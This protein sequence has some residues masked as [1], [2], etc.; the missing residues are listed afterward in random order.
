[1]TK[2]QIF[3]FLK[4]HN[5][6]I[7]THNRN[8]VTVKRKQH[9]RHGVVI[10]IYHSMGN[11]CSPPKKNKFSAQ[12]PRHESVMWNMMSCTVFRL[13]SNPRI[14]DWGR[15]RNVFGAKMYLELIDCAILIGLID[16]IRPLW[17]VK[18]CEWWVMLM[19]NNREIAEALLAEL[20]KVQ[21]SYRI[22]SIYIISGLKCVTSLEKKSLG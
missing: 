4:V 20:C 6:H 1:M 15:G 22:R 19:R 7:H 5:S 8:V 17:S 16:V 21:E 14:L 3:W 18:P 2:A 9:M 13:L 12:S 10:F 11:A